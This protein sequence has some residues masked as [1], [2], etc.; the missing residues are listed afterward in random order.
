[1][2]RIRHA[3]TYAASWLLADF[4]GL[5][6]CRMLGHVEPDAELL[7]FGRRLLDL[8]GARPDY[9]FRRPICARCGSYTSEATS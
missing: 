2:K 3:I 5:T 7:A 9:E 1:M 6:V 4:V 8:Y